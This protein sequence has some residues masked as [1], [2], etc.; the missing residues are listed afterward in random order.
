[1]H[2]QEGEEMNNPI[3]I[4]SITIE[5]LHIGSDMTSMASA[6]IASLLNSPEP[7]ALAAAPTP[8]D[9]RRPAIGEYWPGQGGIYA[10][11]FRT[12][13]G[14]VYG[15]IVAPEEDVGS[16]RWAPEGKRALSDW[17]GLINTAA[18]RPDCPAAKL[19]SEYVRD[20]HTDFYLPA[21]RELQLAAA[22]VP[23]KFST[24]SW[25][26]SS[27][28]H[29]ESYAWAVDFEYGLTSSYRRGH[30]FRVRPFRR[31]IY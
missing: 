15:L 8:D 19:A 11:D 27:T 21:R 29:L 14:T 7:E 23:D 25:Y 28:P 17:D 13:D 9:T 26:W 12:G 4:H 2:E 10:G 24:E 18:L 30:E 5:N 16:A 20:E 22:N 1:M 31:F 6:F 3:A